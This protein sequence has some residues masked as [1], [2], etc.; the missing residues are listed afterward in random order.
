MKNLQ[1]IQYMKE[2]YYRYLTIPRDSYLHTIL[3]NSKSDPPS[4]LEDSAI[5]SVHQCM[6][7]A[8]SHKVLKM[9]TSCHA[10]FIRDCSNVRKSLGETF[11]N[12]KL[13]YFSYDNCIVPKS[14]SKLQFFLFVCMNLANILTIFFT[15]LS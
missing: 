12:K 2:R 13:H 15:I 10:G 5:F 11:I 7:Y 8:E 3:L 6:S 1:T 14:H 4:K 9:N